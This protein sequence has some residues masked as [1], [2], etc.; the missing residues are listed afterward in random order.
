MT[1]EEFC[2]ENGKKEKPHSGKR[3]YRYSHG[4]AGTRLYEIWS[5]MKI[6]TSE[7][8]QPHNKVAYFDRGITVCEE[9]EKF[10]PFLFW[11][12]KSG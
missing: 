5:G 6:R 4:M 9:W 7:K 12:Y 2:I 8:A 11:A 3:A 1:F 10:D